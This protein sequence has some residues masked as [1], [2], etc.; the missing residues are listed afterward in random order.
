MTPQQL[1]L[2]STLL[3]E[4]DFIPEL[5]SERPALDEATWQHAAGWE[6]CINFIIR[7]TILNVA[8]DQSDNSYISV[9]QL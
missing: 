4:T 3:S 8:P 2:L 9:E 6:A 5:R 1:K 7:M